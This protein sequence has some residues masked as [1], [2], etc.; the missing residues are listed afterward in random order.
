MR[1]VIVEARNGIYILR[2]TLWNTAN[3]LANRLSWFLDRCIKR[4]KEEEF[5]Y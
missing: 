1:P 3:G 2:T 4:K 5:E